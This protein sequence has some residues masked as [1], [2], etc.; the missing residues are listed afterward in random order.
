MKQLHFKFI[1][2]LA[3]L[4]FFTS[5]KQAEPF[6]PYDYTSLLIR[7]KNLFSLCVILLGQSDTYLGDVFSRLYYGYYHLGRLIFSNKY[8]YEY[9]SHSHVWKK[10]EE[11]IRE[12]GFLMKSLREKYEYIPLSQEDIVGNSK[13]DLLSVVDS[14]KFDRIVIE[15]KTTLEESD[16]YSQEDKVIFFEEIKLIEKEHA[17]LLNEIQKKGNNN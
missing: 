15:L 1:I 9:D 2:L 3:I 6:N 5:C 10:M 14:N 17:K 4:F 11:S 16:N 13:E 7:S 8:G 12:F